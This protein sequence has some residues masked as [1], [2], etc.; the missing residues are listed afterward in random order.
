MKATEK[1]LFTG[2]LQNTGCWNKRHRCY[3]GQDGQVVSELMEQQAT[4]SGRSPVGCWAMTVLLSSAALV[5]RPSLSSPAALGSLTDPK[6]RRVLS[7]VGMVFPWLSQPSEW[8]IFSAWR[9]AALA[10]EQSRRPGTIWGPSGSLLTMQQASGRHWGSQDVPHVGRQEW[11]G[12]SGSA[13][14][15]PAAG[16]CWHR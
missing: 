12:L 4:G 6:P 15:A 5:G 1:P 8:P 11:L 9:A 3:T 10:P 7:V 13:I 16:G 2:V 14:Q